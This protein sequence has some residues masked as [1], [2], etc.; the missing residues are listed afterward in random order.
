MEVTGEQ[1]LVYRFPVSAVLNNFDLVEKILGE[2][3][4]DIRNNIKLRLVNRT[5]LDVCH[6]NLRRNHK[7]LKIEYIYVK[8]RDQNTQM[9]R[10]NQVYINYRRF[11]VSNVYSYL[12]FLKNIVK[13][14][15]RSL[16]TKNL[17][18]LEPS[19]QDLL[20]ESIKL[21]L[22]QN[23]GDS[24]K[25]LIGMEE[26]CRP[27]NCEACVLIPK[28]CVEYGPLGI[29]N[30]QKSF[31]KPRVFDKLIVPDYLLD[32][33]ANVCLDSTQSKDD[34]LR[35]VCEF[36]P[37]NISCETLVLKISEKRK[38]WINPEMDN[39]MQERLRTYPIPDHQPMPREVIEVMLKQ[40]NVQSVVLK[41]VHNDHREEH[42]GE[43]TRND[44]FTKLCFKDPYINIKESDP[45]FKIKE[46]FVDLTDSSEC[47]AHLARSYLYPVRQQSYVH[48]PSKIR[49]VFLNDKLKIQFSHYLTGSYPRISSVVDGTMN[50]INTEA[51]ENLEVEIMNIYLV[52][53]NDI[54]YF[55]ELSK[56]KPHERPAVYEDFYIS[57]LPNQI[58]ISH[59]TLNLKDQLFI[60]KEWIGRRFQLINKKRNCIINLTMFEND[61]LL[62]KD[63]KAPPCPPLR[64]LWPLGSY[65]EN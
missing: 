30:L 62:D 60:K 19:L 65:E 28:E 37:S 51:P 47:N 7:D 17:G 35:A 39:E 23:R 44:L 40:W 42:A 50:I 52:W 38:V 2:V 53:K 4:D 45:K 56:Q 21:S 13:V 10:K 18:Q 61:H 22:I 6:A 3:T 20:H 41:F 63:Q 36:I 54:D 14:E 29:E 5:F 31:T 55:D 26:I 34:C 25:K 33:I 11:P 27:G 64:L 1:P 12:S 43:W 16:V 32:D 49:R 57:K 24:L 46:V 48:L 58:N 8:A 15:I 59:K 9:I